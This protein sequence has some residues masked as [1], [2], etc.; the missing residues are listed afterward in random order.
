MPLRR[1]GQLFRYPVFLLSELFALLWDLQVNFVLSMVFNFEVVMHALEAQWH[2]GWSLKSGS[3][4]VITRLSQ[5][6]ELFFL[7][8]PLFYTLSKDIAVDPDCSLVQSPS[9]FTHSVKAWRSQGCSVLL[10]RPLP[11]LAQPQWSKTFPVFSSELFL[12]DWLL[13]QRK[14]ALKKRNKRQVNQ[15][16]SSFHII[17]IIDLYWL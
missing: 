10:M 12:R 15:F 17:D 5:L 2:S 13:L 1:K 4:H 16:F 7:A 9:W 11:V 8:P 3:H 6:S 14:L